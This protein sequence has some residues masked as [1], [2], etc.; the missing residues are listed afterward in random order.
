MRRRGL[1]FLFFAAF[2]LAGGASAAVYDDPPPATTTTVPV[3]TTTVPVT[4]TTV[5]VTTTTTP[6]TTI[7]PPRARVLPR[8][9]KVAGIPVGGMLPTAAFLEVQ[10]AFPQSLHV[11][12]GRTRLAASRSALGATDYLWSAIRKAKSAAPG[13]DVEVATAVRGA[14]VRAYVAK[15]AQRFDRAPVDATLRIRD[16]KPVVSKDR[17]G[18]RVQAA[19]AA[20]ELVAA[21]KA[22]TT[23]PV[24]LPS[25]VL[26]PAVT[27]GA[28]GPV[29]VIDRGRNAL[30]LYRGMSPWRHFTVATG[31]QIYPTPLGRFQIVA[32]W[33]NPW[34]YPPSSPWAAGEKPVPPG[35]GN[36]LGTRW[37]GISAPGVGI[38]GTPDAASLGYSASHGC[39]RMAIPQAEWLFDHVA[40]GTPVYIVAA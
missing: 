15:L 9:L 28:F 37:M 34:W 16:V 30:D 5:L 2:A 18:F 39:I 12:V 1:A 35:P 38:H 6:T 36:P 24:A 40:V 14:A 31:Q 13:A 21:L 32:M 29:I 26:E 23:G 7:A 19:A 8:N 10:N 33:K 11:T 27:R 17:A 20:A 4:T 22:H 3:T 25:K